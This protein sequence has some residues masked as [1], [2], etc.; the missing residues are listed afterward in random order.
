MICF[1]MR[2]TPY[3][4]AGISSILLCNCR[5]YKS[6]YVAFFRDGALRD[7][8]I[9]LQTPRIADICRAVECRYLTGIIGTGGLSQWLSSP[10]SITHG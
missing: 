4:V 9:C 5:M 3:A 8:G 6:W 2:S 10:K 7:E 1:C